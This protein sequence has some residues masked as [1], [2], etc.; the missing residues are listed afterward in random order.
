MI[1]IKIKK[2]LSFKFFERVCVWVVGTVFS[3][4]IAFAFANWIGG[5][6]SWTKTPDQCITI[7]EFITLDKEYSPEFKKKYNIK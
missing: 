6:E 2:V 4:M 5:C 3:L 1:N 7:K